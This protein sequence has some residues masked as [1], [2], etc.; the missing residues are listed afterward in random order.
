MKIKSLFVERPHHPVSQKAVIVS[1]SVT[2]LLV[3]LI[4][5]YSFLT[6]QYK[7]HWDS[8]WQ[9]RVK[10]VDGW[11][12]TIW[13]SFFSLI[14]SLILGLFFAIAQRS[15]I[16]PLRYLARVYIELIRGTPL[17]VQILIFFYVIANAVHVENRYLVGILTLSIFAGA[18]TT[19]IIRGGLESIAESQ[20]ETARMLGFTTFQ[21]YQFIIIPQVIRR[22]LPGL[23]GQFVSLIKDSSLLSIISISEFA[24]NAQE[25][26]SYT[27]STLEC[28]LPLAIGYLILTLPISVLSRY[29]EKRTWY[30]N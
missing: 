10:F 25:V 24:L 12:T 2:F 13:L 14:L 1:M 9:Y 28:Y 19:E 8:I 27:Y 26:N 7:F 30:A 20:L 4:F 21:T 22:I 15:H 6:L 5:Y 23:A 18:Y 16:L 17:M 3:G 11:L 29:L